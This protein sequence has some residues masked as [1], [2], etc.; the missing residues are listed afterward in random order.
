[1]NP[2]FEILPQDIDAAQTSII[3]EVSD[4]SFSYFVINDESRMIT[5]SCIFHFDTNNAEKNIAVVLNKILDKQPLLKRYYNRIFISYSFNESL[6]IP[7]LYYDE[8]KNNEN[9]N[10]VYGDLQEGVILTDHV[11]EKELFNTYRIPSNIHSAMSAQF[12]TASFAHQYSLL[13]KQLPNAGSELNVIFYP[14][15]VVVT[16]LK[17]GRLQIIQTFNYKTSE[18]AVYYMLNVCN[19]FQANEVNVQLSGMIEKD[20]NMFREINKYFLTTTFTDL[21]REYEYADGIKEL[22]THF[23]SHLFSTALCV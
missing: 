19:Q 12:P 17:E 6:L 7:G 18:D 16:L 21:P 4:E 15:K 22:P 5:G 2:V 8:N 13:L 1:M 23:F 9:I 10:L 3:V 11:A 14:N 20:S